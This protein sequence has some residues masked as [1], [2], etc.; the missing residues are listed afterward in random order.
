MNV[1]LYASLLCLALAG[2]TTANPKDPF[3]NYNRAMF[4]FNDAVD[5]VALKPAAEAYAKTPSFIRTGIGNF[6]SNLGDPWTALNNLLQGRVEDA[7]NSGMRFAVN[8][9]FGLG[10]LLDIGSAAGMPKHSEDFGQ[11]LGVWG[12][13]QGPYLVL[14]L[15]GPSNVRD[16]VTVPI[17]AS[18]NPLGYI[19][20]V[21][22]RSIGYGV[23]TIDQR[24]ALLSASELLDA[25]AL[26]R[27]QF[28]RDAYIQ[29]RWSTVHQGELPE[30]SYEN[31]EEA[32]PA[33]ADSLSPDIDSKG[34]R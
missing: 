17:N 7:L 26:D 32:D 16:A 24:A 28:V 21:G 18:G 6:F 20:P 4:R 13:A 29:R 8:S 27:Y 30:S 2:C 3:E 23:R 12:V 14:P 33:C 22:W 19:D 10:G 25:V 9:T 31:T 34:C 15:M 11:T 1:N 5:N